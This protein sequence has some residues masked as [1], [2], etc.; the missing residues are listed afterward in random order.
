MSNSSVSLTF[1]VG[2]QHLGRRSGV[3]SFPL[4]ADINIST[5]STEWGKN[6]AG[7]R[8]LPERSV[9]RRHGTLS[10]AVPGRIGRCCRAG[11][12]GRHVADELS[13]GGYKRG[14]ECGVWA[15]LGR[16]GKAKG[17]VTK[18]CRQSLRLPPT[19]SLRSKLAL[20]ESTCRQRHKLGV[21]E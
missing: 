3:N 15:P 19:R 21:C 9:R 10:G 16:I 2:N 1:S 6:C 12:G 20:Y 11:G 7:P 17:T 5:A 13:N 18:R 4:Q 8:P 14:G